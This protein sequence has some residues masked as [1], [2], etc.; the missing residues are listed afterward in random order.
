MFGGNDV[1]VFSVHADS[2]VRGRVVEELEKDKF[3]TV[4]YEVA[5]ELCRKKM[6]MDSENYYYVFQVFSVYA[7]SWVSARLI[8]LVSDLEKNDYVTFECNWNGEQYFEKI[9]VELPKKN[10]LHDQIMWK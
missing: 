3:V 1:R 5:G 9:P 6:H 7:H 10:L 2:W 8:G 4:E